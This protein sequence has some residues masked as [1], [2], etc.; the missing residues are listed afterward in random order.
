MLTV[1]LNQEAL[2]QSF[3]YEPINPAFGGDT[4]NYQWMLNSATAQNTI[5][6]ED[7]RFDRDPLEEF[8]ETLNRQLLSQLSREII[9]SQ[10]GDD[11][12]KEGTYLLGNYQIDITSTGE[13]INIVLIDQA[14]GNQTTILVPFF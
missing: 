14:T 1:M 13:G 2:A 5:E 8:Q 12:F 4:F 7:D 9:I 10:F 6:R 11:G 3:V